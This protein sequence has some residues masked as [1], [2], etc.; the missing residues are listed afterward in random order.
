MRTLIYFGLLFL[1]LNLV[2]GSEELRQR[3]RARKEERQRRRQER[4][5]S[6]LGIIPPQSQPQDRPDYDYGTNDYGTSD[7]QPQGGGPQ[8]VPVGRPVT[9][10]P[11]QVP[12]QGRPQQPAPS[13]GQCP[14]ETQCIVLNECPFVTFLSE[15]DKCSLGPTQSVGI[16]CPTINNGITSRDVPKRPKDAIVFPEVT[17]LLPSSFPVITLSDI[18]Q[19][20]KKAVDFLANM[21]STE[22]IIRQNQ[23]FAKPKTRESTHQGFFGNNSQSIKLDR[24]GTK[25]VQ[26]ASQ[27]AGKFKL[28]GAQADL[29][30]KSLSLAN[31]VFRDE[32]P[33]RSRCRPS[34]YRTPDGSCNNER[35]TD[36]GKSFTAF[37]RIA[38][39]AYDDGIDTPRTSAK[40]GRPLPNARLVS[41]TVSPDRSNENKFLTMMVM[42]WGQFLDHDITHTATSRASDGSSIRCCGQEFESNPNLRHPACLQI[43]IPRND[44]FYVQQ[45]Q[46]CMSFV[47]SATAPRL[48]CNLGPREQLNQISAYID[49]GMVYGSTEATS[50][51][52]REFRGGRLASS[53]VDGAEFLPQEGTC[54]IPA[55]KRLKCFKT[56]DVR[57]NIQVDLI[58]L[59]GV[60]LRQHN[61]LAGQLQQLNPR[62]DDETLYQETRRIIAAQISTLRITSSCPCC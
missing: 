62:W 21:D 25:M 48:N 24:D 30:F 52:L 11:P 4:R 27:I 34:K 51:S 43:S 46:T 33:P 5:D 22:N 42:Q 26:T 23:L 10:R 31:S 36:W 15:S 56:G 32:C 28:N 6:R 55:S 37:N 49:A 3:I 54:G 9:S 17:S 16:C 39:P 61:Q 45:G 57:A 40:S 41:F 8:E 18:Q 13:G 14:R 29:A 47:R 50:R 12:V 58:A 2:A 38:F 35:N 1:V 7:G 44:P 19:A 53:Q 60:W 20:V 59:H